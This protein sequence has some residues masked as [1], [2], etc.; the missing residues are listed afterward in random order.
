L[1]RTR[2]MSGGKTAIWVAASALGVTGF[3]SD[4]PEAS[5]SMILGLE[6]RSLGSQE[7]STCV[8]LESEETSNLI[9]FPWGEEEEDEDENGDIYECITKYP[10]SYTNFSKAAGANN[11]P[12]G[13]AVTS[14]GA[15]RA[16]SDALGIPYNKEVNSTSDGNVRPAGCFWDQ[17]GESYF[18]VNLE[19]DPGNWGGVGAICGGTWTGEAPTPT[20]TSGPTTPTPGRTG[21]SRSSYSY[22]WTGEPTEAPTP[23]R[24]RSRS[25]SRSRRSPRRLL[26]EQTGWEI[27]CVE[28][29]E[30]YCTRHFELLSDTLL[31]S[32]PE[33]V[34]SVCGE[35]DKTVQSKACEQAATIF[36]KSCAD[37]N[38]PEQGICDACTIPVPPPTPPTPPVNKKGRGSNRDQAKTKCTIL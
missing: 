23:G 6:R 9:L 7:F 25:R 28:E 8:A 36:T 17:N 35:A 13:A 10:N 27:W 24:S 3:G 30:A 20:P 11:C 37:E 1:R 34:C 29:F 5:A 33:H 19:A 18:N 21:R 4:E 12:P 32:D 26:S 16:A 31:G 2:N 14:I 22:S 15:C 38:F